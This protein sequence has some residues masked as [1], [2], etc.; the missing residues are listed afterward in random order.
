MPVLVG[1]LAQEQKDL[2]NTNGKS[3]SVHTHYSSCIDNYIY[4]VEVLVGSLL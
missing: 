4:W 3:S 1:E 2:G